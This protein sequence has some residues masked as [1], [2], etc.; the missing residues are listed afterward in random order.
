MII[1]PVSLWDNFIP[2][3][4]GRLVHE[5]PVQVT[6][7]NGFPSGKVYPIVESQVYLKRNQLLEA[8]IHIMAT[9]ELIFELLAKSGFSTKLRLI[10]RNGKQHKSNQSSEKRLIQRNLLESIDKS[11][12]RADCNIKLMM[13]HIAIENRI[14]KESPSF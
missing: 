2:Q 10:T 8:T 3:G 14:A 7:A 11:C 9:Q 4:P 5:P 13:C 6:F 12:E 1:S